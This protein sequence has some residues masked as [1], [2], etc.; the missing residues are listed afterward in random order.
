MKSS[1]NDITKIRTSFERI[2]KGLTS[3]LKSGDEQLVSNELAWIDN[4]INS[5]FKLKEKDFVKFKLLIDPN[6][7]YEFTKPIDLSKINWSDV[8]ITRG[9]LSSDTAGEFNRDIRK[10]N[11]DFFRPRPYDLLDTFISFS[12][13][14]WSTSNEAGSFEAA[15]RGLFIIGNLYSNIA[16]QEDSRLDFSKLF[17]S[18]VEKLTFQ[19]QQLV[20]SKYYTV[21][22]N[23]LI[24]Y[25]SYQFHLT[26]LLDEKFTENNFENIRKGIFNSLKASIENNHL[27]IIKSFVRTLTEGG[28]VPPTTNN[29]SDLYSFVYD[30][31]SELHIEDKS[32]LKKIPEYGFWDAYYAFTQEEYRNLI[33][34]L[35]NLREN[36]F[37]QITNANDQKIIEDHVEE[38]KL[39]V[40]RRYKHRLMQRTLISVLVYALFKKE[41]D[42]VDFA[43]DF[44]QPSDAA[45]TWSNKDIVP[46]DLAEILSVISLKYSFDDELIF[47][48]PDHHGALSYID[49]FFLKAIK[50]W[51]ARKRGDY[52]DE[53]RN[54][55]STFTSREEMKRNPGVLEG[56][57]NTIKELSQKAEFSFNQSRYPFQQESDKK[58]KD[59]VVG[60]IYQIEAGLKEGLDKI[61]RQTEIREERIESFTTKVL[62]Q[63]YEKAFY[64]KLINERPGLPQID[65][66]N[67]IKS[68]L[69]WT[70]GFNELIDRS[71]FLENWHI[72]T[73]GMIEYIGN[74]L[75]EQEDFNIERE[76]DKV[77]GME[78]KIK[79]KDISNILKDVSTEELMVF[80]NYMIEYHLG[81]DGDFIP[82]RKSKE[83][84]DEGSVIGRYKGSM[85]YGYRAFGSNK[86]IIM[87][88]HLGQIAQTETDK[89]A[90]YIRN[91]NFY[92]STIDFGVKEE[93]RKK[94]IKEPPKWLTENYTT[95]K[96]RDDFLSKKIWLR[97]YG[98][99]NWSIPNKLSGKQFII[100]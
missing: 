61:E 41:Y 37:L 95:E 33:T 29:Y 25:L 14:V 71:I 77:F 32:L 96:E 46:V 7:H 91:D 85:V 51:R 9:N 28:T 15:K 62:E 39:Y 43:F 23:S 68:T 92:V 60:L 94:F 78:N 89:Y 70:L 82:K 45:A 50:N 86:I 16:L 38:L 10:Y 2:L 87:N 12:I 74:Q 90:D 31:Y 19:V 52:A 63:F 76:L 21:D 73:Y 24:R 88:H 58:I 49:T 66:P 1:E 55:L 26:H 11:F 36:L 97:I 40:L 99:F 17:G 100:E 79:G 42:L 47:N 22:N 84:K 72:P 6:N 98:T 75:A 81:K 4:K 48:M 67:Q 65:T 5:L 13:K 27:H 53:L 35:N 93:E 57:I 56:L 34:G 3:K 30:K 44:N 59:E 20:S 64:R 18:L 69:A 80:K 54:V 83:F 8:K